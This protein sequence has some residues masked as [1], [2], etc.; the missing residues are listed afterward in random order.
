MQE[1]Y[2][3]RYVGGR[4]SMSYVLFSSSKTF[5]INE[6]QTRFVVDVLKIDLGWN[7]VISLINGIWDVINDG[8]LGTLIDKTH[9]RWGKFRPY[10]FAYSTIG[11]IFTSLYWMTPLFFD[12]SLNNVPK[13]IFWLLLAMLLEAFST[14]R[15]ISETGM[16]SCLSPSPDDRVRLYTMAEVIAP[17]WQ[18]LPAIAMG[19]FI[20]L[21]NHQMIDTSMDTV[22]IG[23][24]TFTM[25]IGGVLA[26]FFCVFA[27]ERIAQSREKYSYREG[28]RTILHNKPLLLL[29]LCDFVG[30]F[31]AETWEHNYYIDV[32]GS[33][34]L[35]NIVRIPGA[36]LSFVSYAYIN[37]A[38]ARFSIK[39]LWIVGS[40][41]KDIFSLLVFGLGSI[42]GLYKKVLPMVGLL[43]VKNLC[44]MGTLSITKIIPREITLDALDYAEWKSG[45]RAEGTILAAKSMSTKIV[46]NVIN[47]MTTLIMKGTGYSLHA[48]FGRQSERAKYAL[49]AMSFGVPALMGL[50]AMI[51]KF[52]YDLTGEKRQRMYSEL[53]EMRRIRQTEYDACGEQTAVPLS[54]QTA[55]M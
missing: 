7:S 24:G 26:L 1:S 29:L 37:K 11:T 16:M 49:F 2:K 21:V 12:K 53:A 6:F 22:F 55:S 36:P 45:F 19:I 34:S 10:L 17:A 33:E 15:D 23:M 47:S 52:F 39:W 30:G 44:Y 27:K 28:L 32:L 3:R 35:R 40:H 38:R 13:A 54:D 42:G 41:L 5:H 14:V 46:R 9:T 50:L 25:V 31:S 4:E 8:L 20:D 48:G 18:D 51:P 43:M